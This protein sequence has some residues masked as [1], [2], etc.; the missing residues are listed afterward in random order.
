MNVNV[1][2][3]TKERVYKMAADTFRKPGDLIDFLVDEAY[4]KMYPVVGVALSASDIQNIVKEEA[5]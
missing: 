3:I 1:E 4:K 5:E 2:R